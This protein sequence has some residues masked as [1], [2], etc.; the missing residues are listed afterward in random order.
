MS[1]TKPYEE[2]SGNELQQIL[3]LCRDKSV[4]KEQD[5]VKEMFNDWAIEFAEKNEKNTL[6]IFK[7]N[8]LEYSC[9]DESSWS[10]IR[11]TRCVT[12]VYDVT[13]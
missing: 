6:C 12:S 3:G 11:A 4:Q 13:Q 10:N 2:F 8:Y 7:W 9:V 1:G 5:K